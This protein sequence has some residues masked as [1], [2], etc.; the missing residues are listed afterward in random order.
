MTINKTCKMDAGASNGKALIVGIGAA[1]MLLTDW[2]ISSEAESQP[3]TRTHMSEAHRSAIKRV[4]VLPTVSRAEQ[5][6]T[7][8]YQKQT[9][10]LIDGMAK[11]SSV[12]TIT[13]DIYGVPVSYGIPVLKLAGALF[14]G[15]SGGAKRQ[16]QDFRDAL[17]A[18]LAEAAD[19]PLTNDALASDVYWGLRKI[20]GLDSKVFALTT[21]IPAD[22]DAILYVSLT[23]VLINIQEKE[24]IITTSASASLRRLSDG[25]HLYEEVIQYQDRNN[26]NAWTKDENA[27]WTDYA[28]FARHYIGREISA[29]VFGRIELNHELRPKETD[30]VARIKKN[31]WQGVSRTRKPTLAWDLTLLGDDSY[32]V[33]ANAF[34]DADIS[35]DVEIYDLH[36]LVYAAEHVPDT[37]HTVALDLE[38]CNSYRWSVRPSYK[39][40][41]DIKFG[42]WMRANRDSHSGNGNVGRAVSEVPAYVQDFATLKIVCGSK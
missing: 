7:G 4:V 18:E 39:V 12:G 5:A 28:N 20:P 40:D 26:L 1:L 27:L 42:E 10:G 29:E 16:V 36:R 13:K 3:D 24:A 38:P 17:T 22:T 11:G 35:Y 25:E 33:W 32:G 23:D 8:S 41:N 34:T 19:Q 21:P 14:G 2:A 6:T 30:S 15:A 9:D 31:E 37:Q